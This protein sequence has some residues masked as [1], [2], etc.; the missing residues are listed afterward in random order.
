[1]SKPLLASD[2]AMVLAAGI[3]KRM[4]PLTVTRPKPLVRWLGKPLIDH[5]LDKLAEAGVAR[6]VVNAHYLADQLEAHLSHREAPVVTMSDE[7][8]ACWKPA[9]EWSRQP[10]LIAARPFFCLNSDNIWLDGPR[11]VFARSAAPGMRIRW[12]RCC[13]WCGILLPITIRALAIST[14]MR[15]AASAAAPMA[16]W[17]PISFGHPACLAPPAARCAGGW[18]F[19]QCAVGPRHRRGAPL[20]PCPY[21]RMD[22][23]GRTGPYRPGRGLVDPHV[24]VGAT[25]PSLWSIPAHRGFADALVAGLLPRYGGDALG[26]ARLTLLLPSQRAIRSV[27]EAF[28]RALGEQDAVGGLLLPR[29]VV[30]GDLDLDEALGALLDPL[31][32]PDVP[33]AADPT[34]RW[35][36][37]A[38]L[39][40]QIEDDEAPK[41]AALLRR[42]G[43]PGRR[44]TA[45]RWRA[46]RPKP[47]FRTKSW[48]W[49]ASRPRIGRTARAASSS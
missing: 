19:H 15:W 21:R 22:R 20:W 35:L 49:W 14:S 26:L 40:R 16:A 39:I 46:S 8:V 2:T 38:A 13:W 9:A 33:P 30:L 4:R 44:W 27:T 42:A 23:G 45:S 34:A 48:R 5:A 37:L 32:G 1:M 7:R 25:T 18:L 3:G 41:G 43:R 17:R 29:M 47:C 31:D 28:V 6:A 10:R 24:M 11:N 36:R 12:M